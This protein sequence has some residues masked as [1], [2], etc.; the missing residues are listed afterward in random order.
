LSA[1]H[2]IEWRHGLQHAR[3]EAMQSGRP[4]LIK[5]LNQGMLDDFW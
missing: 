4:L 5:P 3:D 2:D 1:L